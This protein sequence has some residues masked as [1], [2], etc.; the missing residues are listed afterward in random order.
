M[1][2]ST[3]AFLGI[4]GIILT[5]EISKAFA[6]GTFSTP[7]SIIEIEVLPA[8]TNYV[9][10]I[11]DDTFST[12]AQCTSSAYRNRLVFD[13]TTTVGKA[14]LTIVVGAYLSG[15][16]VRADGTGT[17]PSGIAVEQLRWLDLR[18]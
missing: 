7:V 11:F 16:L 6:N 3:V 12:P 1:K 8:N 13:S 10:V 17:C 4:A 5:L 15:R 2:L 14:Y 18:P 9:Q